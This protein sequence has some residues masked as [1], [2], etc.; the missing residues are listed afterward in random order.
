[1]RGSLLQGRHH[2][3]Q[4]HQALAGCVALILTAAAIHPS[5]AAE[6]APVRMAVFDFELDV[7]IVQF[8]GFGRSLRNSLRKDARSQA[9]VAAAALR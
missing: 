1:M 5:H 9:L 7:M 2:W 4:A 3:A 8:E 6:P